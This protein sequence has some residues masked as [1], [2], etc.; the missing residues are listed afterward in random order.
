[1]AAEGRKHKDAPLRAPR[2]DTVV[3]NM[4]AEGRKH[5]AAPLRALREDT[6]VG[7]MAAEGRKHKAAP[8]RAL[9]EDTVVG[10]AGG[11]RL[12]SYRCFLS[13]LAGFTMPPLP[14]ALP[15]T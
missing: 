15:T 2:E 10:R 11:T 5:K 6:V 4:A 13:D 8:L 3:G 12:Y 9:R 1:M 7:N 14:P